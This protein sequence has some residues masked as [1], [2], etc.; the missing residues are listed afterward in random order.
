VEADP[1]SVGCRIGGEQKIGVPRF[2]KWWLFGETKRGAPRTTYTRSGSGGGAL[3]HF[4]ASDGYEVMRSCRSEHGELDGGSGEL[5][6][7]SDSGG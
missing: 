6:H 4:P 5:R 1:A 2:Q 3:D 7:G